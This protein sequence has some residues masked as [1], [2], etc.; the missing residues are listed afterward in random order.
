MIH[1]NYHFLYSTPSLIPLT[2]LPIQVHALYLPLSLIKERGK[3][4]GK[5]KIRMKQKSIRNTH[6]QRERM[7][8]GGRERENQKP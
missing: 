4:K 7:R 3:L 8:E 6:I 1:P 5:Q 2:F